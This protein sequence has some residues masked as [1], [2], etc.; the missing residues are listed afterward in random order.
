MPGAARLGDK[1][2]CPMDAHG[3]KRCSHSVEGPAVQ[4][5]HN[6]IVNGKPGVRIGDQGIHGLCCGLNKWAAAGGAPTVIINSQP[7][8]RLHDTTLHCGGIGKIVECS[9]DVIIGNGQG[10]LFKKA[11]TSNAPLVDD[12]AANQG[13]DHALL[14]QNMEYLAERGLLGTDSNKLSHYAVLFSQQ[15]SQ[16]S[17][18]LAAKKEKLAE[19]RALIEEG[20]KRADHFTGEDR[21]QLLDTTDR[22][23]LNN[24][25]GDLS[26]LAED[27]YNAPGEKPPPIGWKRL[28]DNPKNLP[29]DLQDA[30]WEDQESGF[31]AALYGSEIGGGKVLAFRGTANKAGWA[32]NFQQGLGYGSGQYELAMDLAK[33][34]KRLYRKDIEITGHSLGGGLASAGSIV[35]N[36]PGYSFNGSG[37]HPNTVKQFS[38]TRSNGDQLNHAYHVK[39]EVLTTLQ[40]PALNTVYTPVGT[41]VRYA[42]QANPISIYK[43]SKG[44]KPLNLQPVKVYGAVGMQ[45]ELP[46]VDEKGRPVS[47][48]RPVDYLGANRIGRHKM[49]YVITGIE[50]QIRDDQHAIAHILEAT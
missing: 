35:T 14:Q 8:V 12:I 4:G 3:C 21:R 19:C 18:A 38:K 41:T 27:V 26:R 11:E 45:H 30:V 17:L 44:E 36:S 7:A 28:S 10:Q 34:T 23:E 24:R 29:P 2:K 31:R 1:A 16:R 46:A 37:L 40:E 9:S 25:A 49:K 42:R 6:V 5:S 20:R 33:D 13:R 43:A 47:I 15:Q 50:K 22:L 48:T 32:N 39:G